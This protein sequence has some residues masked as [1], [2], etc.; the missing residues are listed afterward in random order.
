MRAV[1]LP[2]WPSGVWC[3]SVASCGPAGCKSLLVAYV[4]LVEK[5]CPM[6]CQNPQKR[7][8]FDVVPFGRQWEFGAAAGARE[9]A[10]AALGVGAMP[11][12]GRC[13]RFKLLSPKA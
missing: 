8:S 4:Q 10:H 7:P 11:A 9:H 1:R 2:G 5:L 3:V 13:S 6:G 12:L